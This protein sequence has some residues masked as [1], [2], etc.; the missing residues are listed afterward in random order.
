MNIESVNTKTSALIDLQETLRV[1][2]DAVN[3]AMSKL[4]SAG[5]DKSAVSMADLAEQTEIAR[6]AYVDANDKVIKMRADLDAA[7]E[8]QDSLR[9]EAKQTS[10][11]FNAISR[12][13]NE[14]LE[15]GLETANAELADAESNYQRLKDANTFAEMS[16][17]AESLRNEMREVTEQLLAMARS[18]LSLSLDDDREMLESIET[19]AASAKQRFKDLDAAL[20]L[21]PTNIQIAKERSEAL[22]DAT[23]LAA[24]RVEKLKDI[25][26]KLKAAGLDQAVKST[27]NLT[28]ATKDAEREYKRAADAVQDIEDEL[29]KA[30]SKQRSFEK[31]GDTLGDDYAEACDDVKRFTKELEDAA[32]AAQEAEGKVK[33]LRDASELSGRSDSLASAIRDQKQLAEDSKL[34]IKDLTTSSFQA[35]EQLGQFS[36][37]AIQEIVTSSYDL[38]EAFTN[39]MK[40]VDGTQEQYNHLKESA[41]QASLQNPVS[42]DQILNV[43]ALGGQLGFTITELEEFQRVANGLDISTNMSW[44]DAATNMAQFANIMKMNHDDIGRYGAAIVDLG[45]NFATT[46]ADISD[47]AMRIAGA[48]SSLGLTEA[49]VLGL[50]AA[51]TSMGLTAEAG[52]SSISQIMLKVDKAV[53]NGNDKVKQYASEAGM[54]V[55]EFVQHVSSLDE[56]SLKS[57]AEG[58][59]M[60]ASNF[61]KV[62]S[63]AYESLGLWAEVA[64]YDSAEKFAAAWKSAPIEVLQNVFT[65][66]GKTIEN[67]SEDS[68]EDLGNLSLILDDLNIKTIRQGDVARRLANNSGLLTDAV[69]AA[70]DAWDENTALTTE[71]ERRNQ[72]LSGRMDV[73]KNAF[74]AIK[75]E[76]GEGLKPFVEA[77]IGIFSTI[78][79]FLNKVP[80]GAKTAAIGIMGF[81]TAI[82]GIGAVV[83]AAMPVITKLVAGF[84]VI[85][86]SVTTF[87]GNVGASFALAGEA[88]GGLV[89]I[90]SAAMA[91]LAPLAV[92][93]VAI[94]GGVIGLGVASYQAQK[95][96]N[97]FNNA[98]SGMDKTIDMLS[99]RTTVGAKSLEHFAGTAES[100]TLE[101]L[102]DEINDF[103][104]SVA[105]IQK[106]VRESNAMLGEYQTVID[107]FAGAGKDVD[108]SGMAQLQWAVEGLNSALGTNYDAMDILNGKYEDE[109]GN[110]INI[111][112]EIDNLIAARQR[113]AEADAAMNIYTEAVEQRMR[114]EDEADQK[115]REYWEHVESYQK[116]AI[117][118]GEK[119]WG[120]IQNMTKEEFSEALLNDTG[121]S[122]DFRNQYADM[123]SYREAAN[124]QLDIEAAALERVGK[125]QRA[126]S[127][128]AKQMYE[129][130]NTSYA[131][132]DISWSNALL[133]AGISMNDFV[134]YATA[135]GISVKDLQNILNDPNVFFADMVKESGGD[136]QK[137]IE[138]IQEYN[139]TH[140]ETKEFNEEGAEEVQQQTEQ[141]TQAVENAD[142][143]TATYNLEE[144]GGD[145]VQQ[146]A[147][148]ATEAV[149]EADGTTATLEIESQ[150]GEEAKQDVNEVKEA[151]NG[152]DSQT[153]MT[154][155][156]TNEVTP[157]LE[158]IKGSV[159]AL[160]ESV[161]PIGLKA[162]AKD[163]NE[164][165]KAAQ[166]TLDSLKQND[167]PVL[168]ANISQL[169]GEVQRAQA[170]INSVY[171]KSVDLTVNAT[172]NGY[173]DVLNKLNTLIDKGSRTITTFFNAVGK[174]AAGGIR[175][176][177][178]GFIA[179][180]PTWL[181]NH[182]I[183][184]EA[185]AEAIIPLTNKKYVNPFA[186]A[187]ADQMLSKMHDMD[188]G[189]V[190]TVN[191]N[192]SAGDDAN[193]MARDLARA[194]GR[195]QRTGR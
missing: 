71:V 195:I 85:V 189:N 144:D 120:D 8:L 100:L 138:I 181:S 70:N 53:A 36:R 119:R 142:G 35:M 147:E 121:M 106:P 54:S 115:E 13:I 175:Y 184:G 173:Y 117:E 103:N 41:V 26:G 62:T 168:H 42:A 45:N 88:I 191:L 143:T 194:L 127:D 163:F 155:T 43:E 174:D 50:S 7:Y 18:D 12:T 84:S 77:G 38:E 104:K 152:S 133:Q 89:G 161:T 111:Q 153:S 56:D 131:N 169:A 124:K 177:A 148:E 176:H 15:P 47:M 39:M 186:G 98:M 149:E 134:G 44:E 159:V 154:I 122:D 73:L 128:E 192:Y 99:Q 67:T 57:F 14:E 3:S 141:T 188:N 28:Q 48:G 137:L 160:N 105:E 29:G 74:T 79:D 170:L 4:E 10:T 75:T 5:V 21:N 16:N 162:D 165:M 76:M 146:Q 94:V 34:V 23:D 82:A 136:L 22:K 190:I 123:L 130:L 6:Q 110:L 11:E 58:F 180:H 91:A 118:A 97:D 55:D 116:H 87:A 187:V 19:E 17:D 156:A 31:N 93:L 114:L 81:T 101:H 92:P 37:Q 68:E 78:V 90:S 167:V 64:G 51:L 158:E 32:K 140:P 151:F 30:I 157:V 166:K 69:K 83:A 66:L 139:N 33:L 132:V 129:I 178:D 102:T 20:K 46:E 80:D 61:K 135:A 193:Q 164:T 126:A 24:K 150:G 179:D 109:Q 63:D 113:Q 172:I 112:H 49:D 125:L 1:K 65:G 86:A 185:G 171:G 183:V 2:L 182:D 107:K 145:E 72:S 59:G 27:K 25:I 96:T 95:K 60:T 40:T 9:A 52:G 108:A